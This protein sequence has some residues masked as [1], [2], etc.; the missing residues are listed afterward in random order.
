MKSG[1]GAWAR[2][3]LVLSCLSLAAGVS[4]AQRNP[5]A[6]SVAATRAVLV[7]KAKAEEARGRPD[8]ALQLWQQVLLSKP[9]SAEA[10]A[11]MAR[12]Y[13][14]MGNGPKAQ[15]ALD[16]LRSVDPNNP[17]IARIEAMSS[18]MTESDRLRQAGELAKQGRPEDAMRIYRQIYGDHPPSG[19]IALAYYQTLY[20]TPNGK[21]A[22]VAGMRALAE[23]NPG[24][25]E[26]AIALGAMLTYDQRTRAEGIRIL[27][28]HPRDP[29]AQGALRQALIWNAANP[30]SAAE[31]RKYLKAH[32]QDQEVARDLKEEEARAAQ[33]NTGIARTPEE[34]AAFAALNDHRLDEAEKR[35]GAL[36]VREPANGRAA[37]G[38][39][40][41]RMQQ[42]N[43]GAAIGYL[44][45]AEGDGYKARI[46]D[47]ALAASRF[48]Y[49]MS[50]ATQAFDN[51]QLDA[52]EAKFRQALVMNPRSPEALNGLAGLLIEEQHNVQAAGVYEQLIHLRPN[53]ADGWRGLFIAYARDN[54][55][56]KALAIMARFP[57]PVRAAMA[58]DPDYLRTLAGIYRDQ[59][60][61]SDAQRILAQALELP[62]PGN[63]SLQLDTRL[64]YAG[65]LLDAKRYS[66]A[67]E[68]YVQVLNQDPANLP[69]WEGLVTA[70]HNLGQDTEAMGDVQR[71]PS[72]TYESARA[73]PGFLSL[74][75]AIYQ[76]AN[77]YDVAQGFLERAARLIVSKG[78][79]PGIDL[80]MQIAG[81][82][83]LRNDP[84][85][86]YA[87]Y[88]KILA[89]NPQDPKAWQGL[90]NSLQ[91]ANRNTQAVEELAQIPAGVRNELES[92]IAFVQAEA[93]L[94]AA[95]GDAPRALEYMKL[96][97]DHY[98]RLHRQPPPDM[99]V[100]NAWLL[101]N[102]G[103]DRALYP[104]LMR[105][106][107]RADLTL[108]QRRTVQDIWANWSVRRASIALDNGNYRRAIDILDAARLAFPNNLAVQKSV[109]GGYARLGR[110]KEALAIFKAIPM[111]D[112]SSGDFQGAIGAA[113]AANDKTQ[114]EIWLRQALE[115]YPRDPAILTQAAQYEQARGD[116]ERAAA[117][118]RASIA[119][120]P[121]TSPVDRLA[122][123][124]VYPEEDTRPHKAVTA[125]DLQRLLNPDNEPFE[126]TTRLPP[127]PPYGAD[128]YNG[129]APVVL[130]PESPPR[131]SAPAPDN[132]APN[133]QPAPASNRNPAMAP[134]P[135]GALQAP[136]LFATPAPVASGGTGAGQMGGPY[137]VTPAPQI[138]ATVPEIAIQAN[139]PHSLASDAY[140]GLIFSLMAAGRNAE[141][142]GELN[143]IPPDVRSQLEADV[144][145]VQGIAGLY[146]AVGDSAR[147]LAY[148]HR[149]QNYYLLRRSNPPAGLE[150]QQAWMLYNLH[151]GE[152][153][154]PLLMSLDGR[155]DL[156]PAQDADLKN[157][158]ATWAVRRASEAM[159]RGNT[160]RGVEILQAASEDF[161]GNMTV[162]R[163]VAGAYARIGRAADALALFRTM[164]MDDATPG[165]FDGSISAAMGAG[166]MAQAEIW[167]RMALARYPNNPQ[168]L[169]LAA[170]FEQ[171]RGNS[172]RA[173]A[174]WRAALAAM[175]P[176][177]AIEPLPGVV[178]NAPGM[179]ESPQPGDTRKLLDPRLDPDLGPGDGAQSSPSAQVPLPAW[180]QPQPAAPPVAPEKPAADSLQPYMGEVK[181]PPS[182]A[183]VEVGGSDLQPAS[184]SPAQ[185]A[186]NSSATPRANLRIESEPMNS[187]AAEAQA[188]F[189]DE[190]DA[191]VTQGSASV[192]HNLPNAP[193]KPLSTAGNTPQS[194]SAPGSSEPYTM[195]QYTPSAQEA[196]TG[197]YS[198]PRQTT[199][200][201]EPPGEPQ[202]QAAPPPAAAKPRRRHKKAE[203]QQNP[204]TPGAAPI[205]Q[206]AQPPQTPP[207]ENPP[208]ESAAPPAQNPPA[209]TGTG[210]SDQELE[211][212]NLPPLRGPWVRTE[213]QAPQV[214][215]RE[216]AEMQLQAIEGGYSGWLGGTTVLNYREGNPGYDQLAA[217]EAPFEASTPLGYHGRLTVI[218]EPEFLDSGQ[219]NGNATIAVITTPSSGAPAAPT[220]IQE[221]I[222]TYLPGTT[223]DPN[224]PPQ[225]NAAG[226]GGEV[227]LAFPHFAIAGGYT[228]WGFLV[229]T[230]TGRVYWRPGNGPFTFTAARD[231]EKDS[232][233]S[234]SGLRDPQGTTLGAEGDIWGGVVTNGGEVQFGRGD[235]QS[236]YYFSAG[237]QYLTGYNV[238]KNSRID[239]TGGAYWRVYA[240]PE[241]GTLSIG[242][243]FFAMHYANNQNAF[244]FGMGGYFS[245][246]SYFLAN[247][248]FTW[249]GHY[250]THWHYNIVGALGVQA[251]EQDE[252]QLW[253]LLAQKA[254]E[255]ANGNP[256][257]PALTDVSVNYDLRQQLAY[258][259]GPHWFVGNY[260]E[261]NDARNYNFA[262][263]GFFVR[264]TFREQPSA[265]AAPTGLFPSNGLRPFTVP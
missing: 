109:A 203:K 113:L 129:A 193:V 12:D 99:D 72:A 260:F 207:L 47:N 245:P 137:A 25:P 149:V 196:A 182:Q 238:E 32:P 220:P 107:G 191:Q 13:K 104:A 88:R 26:F 192:I 185:P 133:P 201:P 215:P 44:E 225:Q 166:D 202:Q 61:D 216:Q 11:G 94:Y 22:A 264:Y 84:D 37:A 7:E 263:V 10:L 226:L 131:S 42:R 121:R 29:T 198:A 140:K 223:A 143:K 120:M 28:A 200:Q 106:G 67:A 246:Q 184:A 237:G 36:L 17:N 53:D 103:D 43:F 249:A 35:F 162:R 68:L 14:L 206:N 247:L 78:G 80:E 252:T 211:Q 157:L 15:D 241:Y 40:F 177:S 62:F 38:M 188:R 71:M 209:E 257:I 114:A 219:A 230:F 165:D 6:N 83:L 208:P 31:L 195:A 146:M 168:V 2:C 171:A 60:R 158:W 239:G 233:L 155:T 45:Q 248:P 132:P 105:L 30:A 101:Y 77:Q 102:T 100:Q 180:Q 136:R 52:A 183:N 150:M 66:Q 9:D 59:G 92:H 214:S 87:I 82:E 139:P 228:P 187:E 8:L 125:A 259:I 81:I 212:R 3:V 23:Q 122:H 41:L 33:I 55:D 112:A 56:Q 167:L 262:S 75:G 54:Q 4:H 227:Q 148:L 21:Q 124:M 127:L 95:V 49:T 119:A 213:R 108:G 24:D 174:F 258:Q 164:P 232:Q 210:L 79:Q 89:A 34:R 138:S 236:G 91:S 97:Q 253:P 231:S 65:I 197:A 144:E 153:L 86:A 115:R 251:F 235:A 217:F 172:E 222:G 98:A 76:Q 16:E 96:V 20:A 242:T 204:Q 58:K 50:Q 189:A 250:M 134:V 151:D 256:M 175:P 169:G 179:Y 234:Y 73:D 126:K 48:W 221:P 163:A 156:T 19:P 63:G 161:P 130:E 218:A 159:D 1:S 46:V 243:N 152:A 145:F 229:S 141:A 147:A 224:P 142:L 261:A 181:L 5:P 69:A 70:R 135:N 27:E 199:A 170:R 194:G 255:T 160:M 123:L 57:A 118:Y 117:Y 51:N 74:L 176:G 265:A 64:Q 85:H 18:S 190:T 205:Q 39:G 110:G 254:T 154:Y 111:Q 186:Q 240:T 173:A 93:G 116:N 90:V 128:P 244:T 178:K